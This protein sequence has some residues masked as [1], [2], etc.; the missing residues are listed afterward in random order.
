VGREG[1]ADQPADPKEG[2]VS[3][4]TLD[5]LIPVRRYV[6]ADNDTDDTAEVSTFVT[7]ESAIGGGS[8]DIDLHVSPS[9]DDTVTVSLSVEGAWKLIRQLAACAVAVE[10]ADA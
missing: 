10:D 2:K 5:W 1:V 9:T 7:V 6:A 4:N 3:T 8:G